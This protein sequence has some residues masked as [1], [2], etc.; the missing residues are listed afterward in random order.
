MTTIDTRHVVAGPDSIYP[1]PH[2]IGKA[3]IPGMRG[4]SHNGLFYIKI[5]GSPLFQVRVPGLIHSSLSMSGTVR[6]L[7]IVNP[8]VSERHPQWH[9][10]PTE[11]LH[12]VPV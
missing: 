12:I 9:Q 1:I 8:Y 5:N 3:Y 2:V 4:S 7:H 10:A 6:R 11:V